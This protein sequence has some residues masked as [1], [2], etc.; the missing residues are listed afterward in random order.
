MGWE[1]LCVAAF[2]GA[3]AVFAVVEWF[4]YK[5]MRLAVAFTSLIFVVLCCS[6][7]GNNDLLQ[8]DTIIAIAYAL[9]V[10]TSAFAVR[11]LISSMPR[12]LI[13]GTASLENV[14]AHCW[15]S[16]PIVLVAIA[17]G[18]RCVLERDLLPMVREDSLSTGLAMLFVA[19]GAVLGCVIV[20]LI[21]FFCARRSPAVP[22]LP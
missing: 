21:K 16:W 14:K 17:H 19:P 5:W 12:L 15:L 18:V 13:A 3:T 9:V 8:S 4:E 7:P 2:I 6:V 1:P 22:P 11:V 10:G 20:D